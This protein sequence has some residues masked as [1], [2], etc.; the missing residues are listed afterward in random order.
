MSIQDVFQQ[1][2]D[3][4]GDAVQVQ[5]VTMRYIW[6]AQGR[7]VELY[8]FRVSRDRGATNTIE[9][10]CHNYSDLPATLKQAAEEAKTWAQ[11]MAAI[12]E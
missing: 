4:V 6:S 7:Q 8:S 10:E 5:K 3:E 9:I 11:N 1:F 12:N 2:K